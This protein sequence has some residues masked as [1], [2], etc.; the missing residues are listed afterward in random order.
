[1]VKKKWIWILLILIGFGF[2]MVYSAFFYQEKKEIY[3]SSVD[4]KAPDFVLEDLNGQEFKLSN[5]R[6]HPVLIVFS[7]TWCTYCRE[8]IPYLKEIY[9]NYTNRGLEMINIDIQES[10][11]RVSRFASDYQLPY[12][13]L[14]DADGAVSRTYGVQGVPTIILVDKDGKIVC[15]DCRILQ[16]ILATMLGKV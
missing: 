12:N 1:M 14:L 11:E 13:V 2:Y 16:D 3:T 10:H 8:R 7:T 4:S 6:G 5:R 15:R 9:K